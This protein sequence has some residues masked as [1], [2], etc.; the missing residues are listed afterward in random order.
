LASV[1]FSGSRKGKDREKHQFFYLHD[2][3][4]GREKYVKISSSELFFLTFFWTLSLVSKLS[5]YLWGVKVCSIKKLVKLIIT[6]RQDV[7]WAIHTFL[8]FSHLTFLFLKK[9]EDVMIFF[10][11]QQRRQKNIGKTSVTCSVAWDC[12][13]H[14][15]SGISQRQATLQPTLGM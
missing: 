11:F 6:G 9:W 8:N 15:H 2:A 12:E 5:F 14:V 3:D 10:F 7:L 4:D 1:F 13:I